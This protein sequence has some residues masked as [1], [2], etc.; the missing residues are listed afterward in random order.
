M[1]DDTTDDDATDAPDDEYM[2]PFDRPVDERDPLADALRDLDAVTSV[3]SADDFGPDDD[4]WLRVWLDAPTIDA[5]VTRL[6]ADAERSML[7]DGDGE[8]LVEALDVVTVEFTGVELRQVAEAKEWLDALL[9]G[10]MDDA[11]YATHLIKIRNEQGFETL[12]AA[13]RWARESRQ[14]LTL[15][16]GHV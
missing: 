2:T 7:P 10:E 12:D 15:V 16:A 3:E 13:E 5:E 8:L 9:D 1:T 4:A 6:V 14:A 11:E